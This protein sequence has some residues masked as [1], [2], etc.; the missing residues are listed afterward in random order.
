MGG[1]FIFAVSGLIELSIGAL[2]LAVGMMFKGKDIAVDN[3]LYRERL[4][5]YPYAAWLLLTGMFLLLPGIKPLRSLIKL[6]LFLHLVSALFSPCCCGLMARRTPFRSDSTV[7]ATEY[8]VNSI[9][10]TVIGMSVLAFLL[11]LLILGYGL[12]IL[13]PSDSEDSPVPKPGAS[14]TTDPLCPKSTKTDSEPAEGETPD[15][16]H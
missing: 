5:I 6:N 4:V 8:T 13:P 3:P 12:A 9:L 10:G 14:A 1:N 16:T 7:G 2:V 15:Q 11:A